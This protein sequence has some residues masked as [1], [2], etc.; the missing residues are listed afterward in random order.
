[1]RKLM[2]SA[3]LATHHV[4]DYG[5]DYSQSDDGYGDI[6]A[7]RKLGW[8]ALSAWGSDGWDLGEWPYVVIS[9]RDFSGSITPDRFDLLSVCEGDH[10]VYSFASVEDR[11]AALDY[12]FLWYMA[13][14]S[15]R[16]L[17]FAIDREAL[18]RGEV[19]VEEKYRG[20]YRANR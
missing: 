16:I 20:P 5:R 14:N 17:G 10:T 18:D 1:M 15:E 7:D 9:I 4:S 19:T 8:Q 11:N 2:D 13:R 6:E 3:E 12:L